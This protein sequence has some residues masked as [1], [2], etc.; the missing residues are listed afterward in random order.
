M[1]WRAWEPTYRAI[2]DDFGFS[3]EA[4]EAARDHLHLALAD[5]LPADVD[6]LRARTQA[7]DAWV[8]GGAVTPADVDR[9][10]QDAPLYVAD[11]A[12]HLVVPRVEP[13]II[14]TDLDGDVAA[15]ALANQ[16]GI[17]LAVHAHGDNTEAIRT[18]VPRLHGPLVGTTQAEPRGRVRNFGGFTDGDRAAC[19]AHAMGARSL[20]LVGFDYEHP[21]A[22]PGQDV[23]RKARKLAWARRIIDALPVPKSALTASTPDGNHRG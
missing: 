22:K 2:L 18:H 23:A 14:V 17:P 21:A 16:M 4:D 20:T 5:K 6:A 8:V 19:L 12:A 11:G 7:R 10:P 13:D 15:Q 1:E 3:R 9:I